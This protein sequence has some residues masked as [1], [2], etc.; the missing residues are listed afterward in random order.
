MQ[1]RNMVCLARGNAGFASKSFP[2]GNAAYHLIDHNICT[3]YS[4][5]IGQCQQVLTREVLEPLVDGHQ[6]LVGPLAL[7]VVRKRYVIGRGQLPCM[8]LAET[9]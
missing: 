3:S 9:K 1:T 4:K 5:A 6:M 7:W 2:L 8:T